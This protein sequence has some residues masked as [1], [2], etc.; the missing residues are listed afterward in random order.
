MNGEYIDILSEIIEDRRYDA[1]IIGLLNKHQLQLVSASE[2]EVEGDNGAVAGT[3]VSFGKFDDIEKFLF[4]LFH[5]LGHTLMTSNIVK[6]LNYNT[7]LIELECWYIG[8]HMAREDNIFFSDKTITWVF[9]KAMTYEG[10]DERELVDWA[11]EEKKKELFA[12]K[13]S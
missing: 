10:H 12:W 1:L 3:T 8:L 11:W 2:L 6:L 13:C 4:A 9:K 7:Y 5:E